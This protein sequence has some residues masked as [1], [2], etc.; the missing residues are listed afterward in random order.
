MKLQSHDCMGK[1]AINRLTTANTVTH[2][3]AIQFFASILWV[4]ISL[5][6]CKRIPGSQSMHL[7]SF[8]NTYIQLSIPTEQ[9]VQLVE[10]VSQ[11]SVD[12]KPKKTLT[13]P[14]VMCTESV[15]GSLIFFLRKRKP[16]KP[17]G[18][19]LIS[20]GAAVNSDICILFDVDCLWFQTSYQSTIFAAV[21]FV[22]ESN[23][24]L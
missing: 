3:I 10:F 7:F 20:K 15:L 2:L 24:C 4:T 18:S 19:M 13:I 1:L 12:D 16:I 8:G 14:S 22:F 6:Q 17:T 5:G 9:P 21:T 23:Y 11:K